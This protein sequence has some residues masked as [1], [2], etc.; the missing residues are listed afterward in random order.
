MNLEDFDILDISPTI[1]ETTPVFPGDT[2]Y[3]RN[4]AM[5]FARGD[6]LELSSIATT[7]HIGA[8]ADAP[9]H[10][11]AE[12]AGI[13]E[14]AL[15][16]YVGRCQ[17]IDLSDHP[18][19]EISPQHLEKVEIQAPRILFKTKTFPHRGPWQH[20]FSYL[21]PELINCLADLGVRLVGID[22]PSIDYADA[23]DLLSHQMVYRRD[24]AILEGLD[25]DQVIPGI[26]QLIAAPLKL[27][28]ADASPVRAM[29]LRPRSGAYFYDPKDLELKSRTC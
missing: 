24:L 7:V 2:P 13:S 27:K 21:C 17:V 15:D 23:K 8:H 4:L 22:T 6:H 25:L 19:Q 5:G 26:Y 1:S 12:G 28:G 29:L 10:Y 16:I 20:E 9:I 3:R 14:R 11:H 18:P